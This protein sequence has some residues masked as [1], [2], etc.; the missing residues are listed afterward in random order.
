MRIAFGRKDMEEKSKG[1]KIAVISVAVSAVL[2]LAIVLIGA[3]DQINGWLLGVLRLLRPVLIG[4]AVSYL[5]N[6]YFRFFERKVFFKL[7]PP[8]LRRTLSLICTYLL[9]LLIIALILLLIIPQLLESIAQFASNYDAYLAS[10][11]RQVNK[12]ITAINDLASRAT[13]ND[14]PLLELL[15]IGNLRQKVS[16]LFGTEGKSLME[17]LTSIDIKPITAM[18]SEFF[19]VLADSLF[20]FFISLYLLS[21]KEKRYA[22]IMKLRRALF[23][24]KANAHITRFCTIADRSFGGFLEGKLLDSLIIGVLAYVALSILEF[25]MPSCF[26]PLSASPISSRSS[27]RSSARSPRH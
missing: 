4:L 19:D 15:E 8:S 14:T 6:P 12:T 26:P 10:A 23:N 5:C 18:I 25:P 22:Q 7:R 21:T 24:D 17:Y 20:G 11:I 27:V 1:K 9:V 3:L 13:G 16:A 2:L